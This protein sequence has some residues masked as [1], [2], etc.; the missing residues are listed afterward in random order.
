MV[1]GDGFLIQ[2]YFSAGLVARVVAFFFARGEVQTLPLVDTVSADMHYHS[3]RREVYY[4]VPASIMCE[5]ILI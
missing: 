5:M 3:G 1:P 4:N 2:K